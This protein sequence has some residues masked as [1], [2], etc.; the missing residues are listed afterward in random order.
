MAAIQ[1]ILCIF[2][3]NFMADFITSSNSIYMSQH[4]FLLRIQWLMVNILN[5]RRWENS[6]KVKGM[7]W[8][9]I[10]IHPSTVSNI[11]VE[12][13]DKVTA[14]SLVSEWKLLH[15]MHAVVLSFHKYNWYMNILFSGFSVLFLMLELNALLPKSKL[16]IIVA[17]RTH[18]KSVEMSGVSGIA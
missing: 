12:H 17:G 9:K 6:E 1:K 2:Q 3:L 4:W 18:F 14:F 7:E 13:C 8:V 15:S 11:Y 10:K 5:R 16:F